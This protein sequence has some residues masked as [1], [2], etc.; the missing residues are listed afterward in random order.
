MADILYISCHS[1]LEYDELRILTSLGHRVF[2]CGA[3]FNP[4]S[5]AEHIRPKLKLHQ[6]S[7]WKD[8]FY[9]TGCGDSPLKLSKEFLSRFDYVIAM[10]GHDVLLN[11]MKNFSKK[12]EILWRGIGQSN[13]MI[14]YKLKKLKAFGVKLIRYSPLE[15]KVRG[16]AGEDSLIRFY[17]KESEFK[18]NKTRNGLGFL[19]YNAIKNRQHHNDWSM[20][21]DFVINNGFKIFGSSNDDLPN[22]MGFLPTEQQLDLYKT[23]SKIFCLSSHPAPYTLGFIEAI[24]SD[25]DIFINKH[26]EVW[27]ERFLFEQDY[28]Q[29]SSNIYKFKPDEKI[30]QLFSER[31]AK[32]AW[33]KIIT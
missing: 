20:S 32:I 8:I 17:K 11:N 16:F 3:Y 15:S 28:Q 19:C 26:N 31:A 13:F 33:N 1:V 9:R 29:V 12:T 10:H 7:E 2:S 14:E 24:M 30:K 23:Y 6:D 21:R 18:S 4:E 25:A 5:P 22:Y 27:D